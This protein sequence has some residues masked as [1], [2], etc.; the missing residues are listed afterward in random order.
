MLKKTRT[1]LHAPKQDGRHWVSWNCKGLCE[2]SAKQW[3]DTAMAM[4]DHE[5]AMPTTRL[6][7]AE[8][9]WELIMG[10]KGVAYDHRSTAAKWYYLATANPIAMILSCNWLY[11]TSSC[12]CSTLD[13]GVFLTPSV[14]ITNFDFWSF[15]QLSARK[16]N[17]DE[18]LMKDHRH[19]S[20]ELEATIILHGA[21]SSRRYNLDIAML[22][23]YF[24]FNFWVSVF[25][26]T[27][28][29]STSLSVLM[30]FSQI[31]C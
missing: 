18:L 25:L 15:P 31:I 30:M 6:G 27:L 9:N 2:D 12:C 1:L 11:L 8:I 21:G 29:S 19:S 13:P 24:Y 3:S 4:A 26:W 20:D 5:L 17:C 23:F 7:F 16:H 10:E 22:Y 28:M 14:A